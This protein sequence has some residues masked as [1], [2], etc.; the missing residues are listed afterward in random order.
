MKHFVPP[1][2]ALMLALT[3]LLL[4]A[5]Q[6]PL[7]GHMMD[8]RT[9]ALGATTF[10]SAPTNATLGDA[11]AR[12]PAAA[13]VSPAPYDTTPVLAERRDDNRAEPTQIGDT[14]RQ[15]F[16]M[17]A[18]D[19]RPGRQLPVLGDEAS[20]SY[21]RYL[22]SFEHDIPDFYEAKVAGRGA[23]GNVGD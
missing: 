23:N 19:Q 4:A 22:K 15:L 1:C 5:Q 7:T 17:Q 13:P 10:I 3:P 16:Q 6:S 11:T 2:L 21:R 8:G 20:A 14:V 18:S 12:P 9:D